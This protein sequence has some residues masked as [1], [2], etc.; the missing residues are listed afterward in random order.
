MYLYIKF[1]QSLYRF[2][3]DISIKVEKVMINY[4]NYKKILTMTGFSFGDLTRN[5]YTTKTN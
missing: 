2:V 3:N 4:K 5:V 1:I